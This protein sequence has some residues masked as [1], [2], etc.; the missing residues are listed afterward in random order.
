MLLD[1]RHESTSMFGMLSLTS[2]INSRHPKRSDDDSLH[3][4]AGAGDTDATV[5]SSAS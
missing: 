4:A 1:G 3:E 2:S 5:V